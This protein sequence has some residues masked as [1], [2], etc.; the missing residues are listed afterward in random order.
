MDGHQLSFLS[1]KNMNRFPVTALQ[2]TGIDSVILAGTLLAAFFHETSGAH[3][4]PAEPLVVIG[5]ANDLIG[6]AES[7]SRGYVGS[8]DLAARP[9]LRSGELLE[10][11]PGS[12]VTQHSG[13]GKANQYFLRG[14]NLDHGTD[15]A[16]FLEGVPLN[17][18]GHGHGQ[19]YL[20]LNPIIPELVNS[21]EFGKGPYYLSVGDFSS[22]GY[23]R[24][25][26]VN[27]VHRNLAKFVIG[28]NGFY[29]TVLAGDAELADG[30]L[31]AGVEAQRYDGPWELDEN[32]HKYNGLLKYSRRLERT[33]FDFSL[34]VYDAEW[35][36]T[37]QIPERAVQAGLISRLGNIDPT[38]GG[39]TARYSANLQLFHGTS[40]GQFRSNIYAVYSDFRLFSNFTFLLDDP[41]N[42]DQITQLDRRR[43]TGLNVN[44]DH[45]HDFFGFDSTTT[46]GVQLRHDNIVDLALLQ[47]QARRSLST[48][49]DDDV[50][51]TSLGVYLSNATHFKNWFRT[52]VGLR[53][54]QYWFDVNSS[55]PVNSGKQSD[56]L[57]SPKASLIFGPWYKTEL[58][59]NFGKGFHSNDARGTTTVIDPVTRIPA[60]TVDPLVESF[61]G[62]TGVR[63]TWIP[64]LQT[65]LAIWRLELDSELI[66]V[67][68]AGT[69]EASGKS[70][71]YGLELAN[72]HEVN[73][74]LVLDLDVALTRSEFTA[75]GPDEIPN[76][77]GRVIT[78]GVTVDHPSGLFGSLRMRHFG[79]S[80][81]TEDGRVKADS[82]TV[83]NL[84]AGF[85]PGKDLEL[86]LDIFNLF[87]SKDPDISYFFASCLS[88]ELPV[89]TG[90][91]V[92]DVH[93]HPVEPR[94]IRGTLAWRF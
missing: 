74:W 4:V 80:P 88:D 87:N 7:A 56:T 37:D 2:R 46:M 78:A 66:F 82:T 42:G 79:D 31:L 23:A 47:S 51:Q 72:F 50:K 20:D 38:L 19:G 9:I 25:S 35:D 10:V 73:D 89:C 34:M 86:A 54:D 3:E 84:R 68:D 29:R 63:S 28:E 60:D 5:R 52:N 13:T 43:V 17:L 41:V 81:L 36:S 85:R 57:I 14:F 65:T 90:T 39:S 48:V 76:S 64:G 92:E 49:R 83:F 33:G 70:R 77:I 94:Q 62:E 93:F 16:G 91:G 55:L 30:V 12:A 18:P 69:T 21:I 75:N 59:L 11:V 15:F 71:R 40:S 27:H 67:G 45:F 61:G 53:L 22:A 1:V 8:V 32:A 26:L 58:Y 6:M 24:Y 44:H